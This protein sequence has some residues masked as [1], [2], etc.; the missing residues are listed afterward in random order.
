[1]YADM[2]SFGHRRAS[3]VGSFIDRGKSAVWVRAVYSANPTVHVLEDCI[4]VIFMGLRQHTQ[5]RRVSMFPW[6]LSTLLTP[7]GK[8]TSLTG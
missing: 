1:M 3:R 7:R 6:I 2:T 4:F 8:H 5:T